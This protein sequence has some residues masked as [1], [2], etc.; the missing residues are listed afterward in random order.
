MARE[1]GLTVQ[2]IRF[3]DFIVNQKYD[4]IMA[5]SSLIHIPSIEI[6][7]Q[8]KKI[9]NLLNREGVVFLSF[10]QGNGEGFEDPT[11]KGKERY[12]SKFSEEEIQ[13]MLRPY[14]S[15][16]EMHKIEVKSMNQLFL[17][18]ALKPVRL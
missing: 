15:I 1:K 14:F 9:Y 6:P 8:I 13:S 4:I 16:I 10:I 7:E 3:Q 12:F 11:E 18:M 5:I 2:Q 17:L